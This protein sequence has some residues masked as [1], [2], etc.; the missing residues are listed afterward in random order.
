MDTESPACTCHVP[1]VCR[2]GPT[3]VLPLPMFS[4][5]QAILLG[6][7]E[8]CVHRLSNH[9]CSYKLLLERKHTQDRGK[10]KIPSHFYVSHF[11][12]S[13]FSG[14]VAADPR[15][16][17][18]SAVRESEQLIVA[19]RYSDCSSLRVTE[20]LDFLLH[21]LRLS[22][23]GP[24]G[25]A[26]PGLKGGGVAGP[27]FGQFSAAPRITFPFLLVVTMT[28][29]LA[30]QQGAHTRGQASSSLFIHILFPNKRDTYW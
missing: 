6:R 26:R 23:M 1:R 5:F 4:P 28:L 20:S 18:S 9:S 30:G 19:W 10:A 17:V 22:V 2:P 29:L 8:I 3:L 11:L 12:H 13:P 7:G 15:V 14:S 16:S 21:I 24:Y 27:G 25:E